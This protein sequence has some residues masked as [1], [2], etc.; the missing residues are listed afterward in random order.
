MCPIPVTH[1][2]WERPKLTEVCGIAFRSPTSGAG[3][4]HAAGNWQSGWEQ[5]LRPLTTRHIWDNETRA[6]AQLRGMPR[7]KVGELMS[8][9]L[10]DMPESD[11]VSELMGS[12]APHRAISGGLDQPSYMLTGIGI[13]DSL[14]ATADTITKGKAG[15][16][17]RA[18]SYLM[19]GGFAAVVNLICLYV[20]NDMVQM[21][22]PRVAHSVVA[23]LIA[24]EIS[25]MANFIPNDRI[26]FSR[27]PGHARSWWARCLRFHSTAIA[28]TFITFCIFSAL[29][30]W[31]RYPTLIAESTGIIIALMFNFTAHHLW[32]YRHLETAH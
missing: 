16:L 10:L 20:F 26:T 21:P 11:P 3:G 22:F 8:N 28:G 2:S 17:Q 18:V 19:V 27:L 29:H 13:V 30:I 4:R 32:T 14:L 6:A 5:R 24:S 23:F 15:L 12:T 31:L 7:V 25:I 9:G 1:W